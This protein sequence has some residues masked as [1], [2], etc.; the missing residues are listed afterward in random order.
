MVKHMF[1][2]IQEKKKSF[3]NTQSG[4][5]M[6]ELIIAIFIFG[7]VMTMSIGSLI[8]ALDANRKAQS[9][10]SVLNNL[11]VAMDT[12]TKSLSAGRSY[13]C[14]DSVGNLDHDN[15]P[16][17][18]LSDSGAAN[19]AITFL[20]NENLDNDPDTDDAMMYRFNSAEEDGP[21]WI[22][23][24]RY[25][26]FNHGSTWQAV[27]GDWVRMTA[28]EVDITELGFYLT[29]NRPWNLNDYEQP[30]VRIVIKG[31]VMSGVRSGLTKFAVQTVVTQ[32]IPDF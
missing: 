10:K 18:C 13:Q 17:E 21:G 30:K 2:Y 11:D 32:L 8:T 14:G 31:E 16:T 22:E 23:R 27:D 7:I 4:F 25:H 1:R 19:S 12:M 28:P 9:L 15:P 20:S 26:S 29:G 6:I 5:L 24:R 3:K